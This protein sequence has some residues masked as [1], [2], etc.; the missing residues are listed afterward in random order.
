MF[1]SFSGYPLGLKRG[2]PDR[3]SVTAG[4][5]R[6]SVGGG[7]HGDGGLSGRR[8][9]CSFMQPNAIT[10]QSNIPIILLESGFFKFYLNSHFFLIFIFL[11]MVWCYKIVVLDVSFF[12]SLLFLTFY[13]IWFS[14]Y[15]L[16]NIFSFFYFSLRSYF[17][18]FILY[19]SFYFISTLYFIL[20]LLHILKFINLFFR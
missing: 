8:A 3:K 6:W 17:H 18:Q 14:H 12:Y 2:L 19:L 16:S 15:F 1:S 11:F 7:R 10:A 4:R 13:F 9:R 20:L 5:R